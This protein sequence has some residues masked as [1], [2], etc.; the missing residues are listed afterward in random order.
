MAGGLGGGA[1]EGLN[2]THG[3][4]WSA[5]LESVPEFN[6]YFFP[7]D[8]SYTQSFHVS[9]FPSLTLELR[10]TAPFNNNSLPHN[11]KYSSASLQNIIDSCRLNYSTA[12]MKGPFE[13]SN[14]IIQGPPRAHLNKNITC[15]IKYQKCVL[16]TVLCVTRNSLSG[17]TVCNRATHLLARSR[18]QRKWV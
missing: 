2:R 18:S 17:P 11:R 9:P 10:T 15:I 6:R 12:T 4:Y 5:L 1:C 8:P 13:P 16:L 7:C 14:L 3:G